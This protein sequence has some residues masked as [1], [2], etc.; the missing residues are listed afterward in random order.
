M[1]ENHLEKWVIKVADYKEWN[2]VVIPTQFEVLWRLEKGDYSYAKFN[3]TEIE[4]DKP[5]KF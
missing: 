1:D 5:M 2:G 3:I 4:Y